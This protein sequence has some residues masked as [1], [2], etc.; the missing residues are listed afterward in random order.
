VP[1]ASPTTGSV[2]VTTPATPTTEALARVSPAGTPGDGDVS[3][4][5]FTLAAPAITVTAPNTN[6]GWVIGTS[7]SITWNHNLGTADAVRIEVSRDGGAT[8]SV[9]AASVVNSGATSGTFTWLVNGPVTSAARVR[10]AWTTD[11]AVQDVSNVDFRVL[12]A[13]T[14]TAPNTALT[15]GAGSTRTV[16]WNHSLGAAATFDLDVSVDGGAVWTP[17]AAA[18]A[19]ATATTGSVSVLMPAT[20]TTQALVRVSPA[21]DPA[22]GDVSNVT[23]TLATPSITVTAPNTN[24]NWPIGA[25]R[26]VTWSHNLGTAE[27]VNIDVSRDGGATWTP[28]AVDVLNSANATGTFSWT[29]TGP[30]TMTARIRVTWARNGAATD[31]S[32]VNFRIQ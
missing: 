11:A 20:V 2:T 13:I 17:L 15:W 3:N 22:S 31:A 29:V 19:A 25:N 9:I 21:G 30:A 16:T 4:V 10:L 24:V 1:A 5:P 7:R 12:P 23:F 14:V 18:I 27:R 6:V 8:W 32:N 28:I 26:N